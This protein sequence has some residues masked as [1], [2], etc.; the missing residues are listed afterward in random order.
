ML[1]GRMKTDDKPNLLLPFTTLGLAYERLTQALRERPR[2]ADAGKKSVTQTEKVD[3]GADQNGGRDR[4]A[5]Q[6][7]D[8]GRPIR[9]EVNATAHETSRWCPRAQA[10][11]LEATLR[12]VR[13]TP[14]RLPL[15]AAI[16]PRS[17]RE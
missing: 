6:D 1:I 4:Q 15:R 9:P 3:D 11:A 2:Q 16:K 14:R 5:Y 12:A 7:K 10:A 8:D 17:K 13:G